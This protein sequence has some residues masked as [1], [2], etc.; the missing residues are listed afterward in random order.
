MNRFTVNR[1]LMFVLIIGSATAA[2]DTL[3][4]RAQKGDAAAQFDLGY[5][6]ANGDGVAKDSAEAVKWFR[7]AAEQGNARAQSNLGAMYA[8]G[9]GVPKDSTEAVKWYRKA[10]EQGH[11]FAQGNLGSMY[12]N[13]EGVPKDAIE[14][15]AWSNSAA[16]SGSEI[17]IKNRDMLERALDR[18]D[19]GRQQRSKKS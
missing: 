9:E 15:L 6:Y 16:A 13:G 19:I 18:G 12:A 17:F 2:E 1:L 3:V 5:R 10:A 4:E 14:G 7:M 11:V 8:N